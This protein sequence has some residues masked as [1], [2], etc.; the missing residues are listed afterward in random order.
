MHQRIRRHGVERLADRSGYHF[1]LD[2]SALKALPDKG[3]YVI[4]KAHP[5]GRLLEHLFGGL[6]AAVAHCPWV[7][8]G[9]ETLL[10]FQSPHRDSHATFQAEDA[11]LA[12]DKG[13]VQLASFALMFPLG[14]PNAVPG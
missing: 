4:L 14:A 9:Q 5:A 10:Q 8:D 6:H 1:P 12:G 2:A 7:G 13:R 11:I 3:R